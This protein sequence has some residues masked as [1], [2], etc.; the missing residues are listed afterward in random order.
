QR[1]NYNE[2]IPDG[3]VTLIPVPLQEDV[4]LRD[5]LAAKLAVALR[6]QKLNLKRGDILVIKHK[7]VSKAEGRLVKL[8]SVKPSR[9]TGKW[10]SAGGVDP[11]V[12][13][14]ALTESRHALRK[15]IVSGRGILI[16]E[17]R[18]GFVC[19]NSG[20]DVSNVDGGEHAVLLPKDPDGSARS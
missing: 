9:T 18:H 2:M 3:P 12:I 5:D 1:S 14:L 6:H 13:H 19:A 20:V 10:A 11:R 17:T 7:I 16:T 15:K 4:R 8:A